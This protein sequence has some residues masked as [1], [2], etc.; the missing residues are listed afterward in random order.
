M[1]PKISLNF[2]SIYTFWKIA[3]NCEKENK[4]LISDWKALLNSN[5]YITLFQKETTLE[6]IKDSIQAVFIKDYQY[7]FNSE[8]SK[9]IIEHFHR[10]KSKKQELIAFIEI[11]KSN[12]QIYENAINRALKF[13]P[14]QINYHS[15]NISF[16]FFEFDARGY[17]TILF[18]L[19]FVFETY[20][21]FE[22]QLAHEF[23][24]KF[25]NLS[26][27]FSYPKS[28]SDF[29]DII[30]V[31]NQIHLEGIADQI[32]KKEFLSSPNL[33][34]KP[35]QDIFSLKYKN[36]DNEFRAINNLLANPPD[37]FQLRGNQLRNSISLSGHTL[38]YFMANVIVEV[39]SE[40]DLI[41]SVFDIS[42]FFV[43]Y[44]KAAETIGKSNR[45]FNKTAMNFIVNLWDD[46]RKN[47]K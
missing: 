44:N 29:N 28:K 36:I 40:K 17:D 1:N 39:F 23:H 3:E 18:D 45:I 30:W 14:F 8:L 15:L 21:L 46:I 34:L 5:G 37:D 2:D 24:H 4:L 22:L 35:F 27:K 33:A 9:R 16:L 20:D 10:I 12:D 13:L 19:L 32:D 25:R 26:N 7:R 41:N 47:A 38:G 11:L 42:K 43:L 31:L 6:L